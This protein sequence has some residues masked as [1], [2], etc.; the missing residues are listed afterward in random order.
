MHNPRCSRPLSVNL[1]GS[2]Q[3]SGVGTEGGLTDVHVFDEGT[4]ENNLARAV[5]DALD[6]GHT[7][8]AAIDGGAIV[9]VTPCG[10]DRLS[11][12]AKEEGDLL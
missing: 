2:E 7:T 1:V 10:P 12:E 3:T 8:V 4:Q 6:S 11:F 5:I 9:V